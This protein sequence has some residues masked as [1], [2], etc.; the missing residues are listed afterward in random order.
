MA[1]RYGTLGADSLVG[2]AGGD[3]ISGG[4]LANQ[5]ADTGNDTLIGGGGGDRIYGWGGNDSIRGAYDGNIGQY[6]GGTG[7]DSIDAGDN[8]YGYGE[9]G[10]DTIIGGGIDA[11]TWAQLEGGQGNDVLIASGIGNNYLLGGDGADTITGSAGSN[12]ITDDGADGNS[13]NLDADRI[14]AGAGDDAIESYG[15]ADTIDGGAGVDQLYLDLSQYTTAIAFKASAT[16]SASI[17][18]GGTITGIEKF[19]IYTGSGRD[20]ITTLTGNDVVD[21]GDGNDLLNGG[22][23]NDSL[24]G[25]NGNDTLIGGGGRDV[26][27]NFSGADTFR[28]LALAGR[29]S[30]EGFSKTDDILEFSSAAVGGLL[31]L[32]ALAAANFALNAATTAGPQFVFNTQ[33]KVL[34]WDADGTGSGLAVQIADFTTFTSATNLDATDIVIIA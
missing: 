23:G 8:S 16:G 9:A 30:I 32:G 11:G 21:S 1:N 13:Y 28:Y 33:T 15:G 12:V 19:T 25:G 26:L 6:F 31:P 10:N 4:P 24:Y 27:S 14:V 18:T 20:R 22:G 3:Y 7:D 5:A 34:S 29:D 2:T 17:T